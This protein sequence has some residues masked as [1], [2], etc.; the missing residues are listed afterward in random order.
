[1]RRIRGGLLLG[2]SIV[3]TDAGPLRLVLT[4][5]YPALGLSFD[6]RTVVSAADFGLTAGVPE[7]QDAL[8]AAFDPVTELL[9]V[10]LP[11]SVQS[12]NG[13]SGTAVDQHS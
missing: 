8:I 13:P 3:V 6:P 4:D 7:V 11:D 2:G 9:F 10:P 12:E 5:V 1:M